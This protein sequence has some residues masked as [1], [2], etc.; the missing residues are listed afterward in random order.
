VDTV[1]Q[2]F[3]GIFASLALAGCLSDPRIVNVPD[4]GVEEQA[5]DENPDDA[6][7]AGDGDDQSAGVW[8]MPETGWRRGTPFRGRQKSSAALAAMTGGLPARSVGMLPRWRAKLPGPSTADGGP[9]GLTLDL[10]ILSGHQG[11]APAARMDRAGES[12]WT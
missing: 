3:A 9:R 7:N 1:K 12:A 11:Q 6:D 4:T 8:T 5:A 10:P 2:S